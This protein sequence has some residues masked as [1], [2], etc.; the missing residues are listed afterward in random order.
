MGAEDAAA[1]AEDEDELVGGIYEVGAT[2]KAGALGQLWRVEREVDG[3]GGGKRRAQLVLDGGGLR[4]TFPVGDLVSH[5]GPTAA[6]PMENPYCS[7]KVAA[8]SRSPY[9]GP[10]LQL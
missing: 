1:K 8:Y 3:G 9:G 4:K 2:V 10:L 6:V 7:C 5:H